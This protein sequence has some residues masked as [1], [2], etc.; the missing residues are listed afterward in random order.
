MI[1]THR[2]RL[3]AASGR[4]EGAGDVGHRQTFSTPSEAAWRRPGRRFSGAFGGRRARLTMPRIASAHA[5][6]RK[7]PESVSM[8]PYHRSVVL[9]V[10]DRSIKPRKIS[11][12]M[13][14]IGPP[15]AMTNA[16]APRLGIRGRNRLEMIQSPDAL[17]LGDRAP[18]GL[19]CYWYATL[20]DTPYMAPYS[21]ASAAWAA[22]P[23]WNC[24]DS[25]EPVNAVV[26]EVPPMMV[27]LT[28]SK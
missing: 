27:W 22:S 5:P 20:T 1:G 19:R 28:R 4:R 14:K 24:S 7:L 2:D 25:V 3:H 9:P 8:G 23:A 15:H 26:D 6:T 11:G 21:A 17:S 16:M 10:P 12:R 13:T 18:G